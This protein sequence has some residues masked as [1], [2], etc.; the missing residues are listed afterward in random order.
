M[1]HR[2][3]ASQKSFI[4]V[5][6]F[7]LVRCCAGANGAVCACYYTGRDPC[8]ITALGP[9]LEVGCQAEGQAD[10]APQPPDASW[11]KWLSIHLRSS[12]QWREILIGGC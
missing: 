12:A 9:L 11:A 8:A 4:R 2:A 6:Y 5:S 10:I 7:P 1:H 3:G